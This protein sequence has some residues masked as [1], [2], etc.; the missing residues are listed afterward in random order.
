V[1]QQPVVCRH[2]HRGHVDHE[3]AQRDAAA[4]LVGCA[5]KQDAVRR[6]LNRALL[7]EGASAGRVRVDERLCV[8][9]ECSCAVDNLT[10]ALYDD[11][12]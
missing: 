5:Y 9:V 2:E 6:Q 12:A 3:L 1:L 11:A 4:A 8:L 7:F 10:Y